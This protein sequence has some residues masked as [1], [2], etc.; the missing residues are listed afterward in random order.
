MTTGRTT[1]KYFKFQVEDSGGTLRDIP[2]ATINDIGLV[3]IEATG[4]TALQDAVLGSF[5]DQPNFEIDITGPYSNLAAQA[6]SGSGAAPAL[7]GSHTVLSGIDGLNVPLGFGIY[8]GIQANWA[9]GDP[10][11]GLPSSATNG[12]VCTKYVAN[13]STMI[14]SARF[15]MVPGSAVPAWGTS[16][17][18]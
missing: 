17:I 11:M 15:R 7:S 10:V 9:T 5:A 3:Y 1:P 8:F 14:Y 16:A 2:V 12:I 18:S 6:A 4:L 13:P